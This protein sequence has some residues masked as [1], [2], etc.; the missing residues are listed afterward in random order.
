MV[1]SCGHHRGGL[2]MRSMSRSPPRKAAQVGSLEMAA[3]AGA[4]KVTNFSDPK[5]VT[6]KLVTVQKLVT[7]QPGGDS[8]SKQA[9]WEWC[10]PMMSL[11]TA[12]SDQLPDLRQ[13]R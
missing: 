1:A 12:T 5:L 2:N 7:S 8:N 3:V 4:S 11:N 13:A 6:Q 10:V 9:D